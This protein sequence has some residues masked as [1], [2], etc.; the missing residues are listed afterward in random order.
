MYFRTATRP[1][2]ISA[3]VHFMILSTEAGTV[4]EGGYDG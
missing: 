4:V 3:G 2:L 1:F